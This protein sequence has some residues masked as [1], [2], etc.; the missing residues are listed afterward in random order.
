MGKSKQL[1]RTNLE[2]RNRERTNL[3]LCEEI[4]LY[5]MQCGGHFHL[6]QPVGSE[7]LVQPE[8]EQVRLGTLTTIF[9][10]CEVGRLNWKGESLRK[11]TTILT[12]SRQ[13][14]AKLD[15]RYCSKDHEHRQ[16]AGQVK[17]DGIWMPLSSFAAKYTAGFARHILSVVQNHPEEMPLYRE[18]LN[19]CHDGMDVDPVLI[20]EV[21]KRRRLFAKQTQSS[22][23]QPSQEEEL[24]RKENRRHR[25]QM[26]FEEIEKLAPRVGSVV[27]QP[28]I[29][30]V[31]TSQRIL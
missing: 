4:Y 20:G 21:L 17:S 15:S 29:S 24:K 1:R 11:R 28:R 9:D 30:R 10:M 16:I 26:L 8:L 6:E 23:D 22:D 19:I 2:G 12:T 25:L 13:M 3:S 18:E 5:Q 14:H 7:A 27:L 31:P